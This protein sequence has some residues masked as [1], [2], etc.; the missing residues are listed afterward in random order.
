MQSAEFVWDANIGYYVATYDV[1]SPNYDVIIEFTHSVTSADLFELEYH[2][3]LEESFKES[4]WS[5]PF[6]EKYLESRLCYT[7]AN[8]RVMFC[9]GKDDPFKT[10]YSHWKN[11]VIY[12]KATRNPPKTLFFRKNGSTYFRPRTLAVPNKFSNLYCNGSNFLTIVYGCV[13]CN[14]IVVFSHDC[15]LQTYNLVVD[16]VTEL[17]LDYKD[18]ILSYEIIFKHSVRGINFQLFA[19]MFPQQIFNMKLYLCKEENSPWVWKKIHVMELVE[20][21]KIVSLR[22]D[23]QNI[24]D[25]RKFIIHKEQ[26]SH[27]WKLPGMFGFWKLTFSCRGFCDFRNMKW[28]DINFTEPVDFS[29][30]DL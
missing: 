11:G 15:E 17:K 30:F 25:V 18:R 3:G 19:F 22:P 13:K 24:E 5:I 9:T 28:T 2:T 7:L 10:I 14:D 1:S 29:N 8:N 4:F 6:W 16:N 12:F 20:K 27:G 21:L 26:Q 23:I